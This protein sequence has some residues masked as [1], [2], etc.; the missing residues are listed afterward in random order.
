MGWSTMNNLRCFTPDVWGVP[1]IPLTLGELGEHGNDL[2]VAPAG[3]PV[4]LVFK[5]CGNSPSSRWV[6]HAVPCWV[7]PKFL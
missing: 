6:I 4:A 1:Q 7:G 5:C 3:V 2:I